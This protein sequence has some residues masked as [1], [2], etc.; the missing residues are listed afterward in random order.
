M[1][2]TV[3]YGMVMTTTTWVRA[4]L[5]AA[6]IAAAL[7]A[8]PVTRLSA[9]TPDAN[10]NDTTACV[11]PI[12]DITGDGVRDY[13]VSAPAR[14]ENVLLVYLIAGDANPVPAT[15]TADYLAAH[16]AGMLRGV[17]AMPFECRAQQ[18]NF[19]R[20]SARRVARK[21]D[22]ENSFIEQ[23]VRY[24]VVDL[25]P[26]LG[27]TSAARI[28]E[29]GVVV[30][31]F[32][33]PEGDHAFLYNGTIHDLGTLGGQSSE[34]RAINNAGQI[35]GYSLTGATDP[36]GFVNAAFLFD[37]TTL[38]NLNLDWSSAN[39]INDRGQI[40]GEM[41][42]TPG[43]DLLHAFLFDQGIATDLGSLPPLGTAYS[44]AHAINNSA[45]I[46]GESNTF[47]LGSAFPTRRY[48]ATRAFLWEQ[49]AMFDLGAL[50][51]SCVTVLQNERCTQR[52]VATDLNESGVVVGFSTT[53]TGAEHAFAYDG[54]QMQDLG[55]L[56]G[57]RSW[58]YGV[59]DSG[60]VVGMLN[61]ADDSLRP[62]LFERGS[63]YDLN[64]LIVN[65]SDA[66]TLP[67]SAYDINNFGQIV[68]N[69]HVLEPLYPQVQP[70]LPLTFTATLG[71]TLQFS[72][73]V[74]R[75]ATDSC[76]E[77]SSR[78]RLEARIEDTPGRGKSVGPWM[79]A[80]VVNGCEQFSDWKTATVSLP[81]DL[82]A[83]QPGAIRIRVREAG[84]S[85][86]PAVYLRHF[87]IQ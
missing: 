25:D 23:P 49:G 81:A 21:A 79:T 43:V 61:A 85:T 22:P 27:L 10:Q 83:G 75:S 57:S 37:G 18:T 80:D 30:G 15:L 51:V 19:D 52:S 33:K 66:A 77:A 69:H 13:A 54:T 34:A 45:Q 65:P 48:G 84:P 78:L 9:V 3:T 44:T 32:F 71:D 74:R 16:F 8:T 14:R 17:Q 12:G 67:F 26:D 64:D 59:N 4:M 72:Y 58:A 2:V 60:Q 86:D 55:A 46:V 53:N 11:L 36:F 41:R 31:R 82:N 38:H 35:V 50:G 40:V 73:W 5:P 70:G 68:G 6:A 24:R 20:A 63:M 62:F 1:G 76:R 28:N 56:D 87:T 29:S 39:G 42:F 7:I 47:V